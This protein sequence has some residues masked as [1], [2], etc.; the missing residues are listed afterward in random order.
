MIL[1]QQTKIRPVNKKDRTQLANLIHF[2]TF[3]HRHLDWR[4]PLEW[5]GHDPFFAL[6][7]EGRL[8]AALACPPDPPAISW[9]RVFVCSAHFPQDRA[10]E[11][12][13]P[14]TQ[15]SLTSMGVKHL[16][17][18]P[19]QKWYRE[20]I[21]NHGF[22][23]MHNIISL[24][25]DNSNTGNLPSAKEHNIR[26]MTP[27]DLPEVI[28]IDSRAFGPLWRNSSSLLKL[29]FDQANIA[30]VAQD[31]LGLIGYQI[32]TP[33]QYGAHLGRLA[34]H[35]RAQKRGVAYA[36]LRNLQ[37]QFPPTTEVRLSVNTQDTNHKSIGLY[38]KAGFVETPETFPV[39][40]YT[41]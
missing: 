35:P 12:L 34:T 33:T 16:A 2:G 22:E 37:K 9:V 3:V 20:L 8:I 30:T 11:R 31:E 36:L 27:E 10:W 24:S 38:H 6:E 21:L 41:F 18:I 1:Q 13:W 28:E 14:Q 25:W 23:Y 32:S 17:A 7:S 39:F 19:L 4:P 40:Q 15:E 5:I 29:A 26:E